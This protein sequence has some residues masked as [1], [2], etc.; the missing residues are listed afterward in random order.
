MDDQVHRLVDRAWA[1]YQ[2]TP[3]NQRLLIGIAGIPGS[4]KTTL[5]RIVSQALNDRASQASPGASHPPPATFLPMD[6]FHL[7]RAALDAMPDPARAHARRGAAFTFDAPKFL[8]LVEA[9]R[10][11]SLPGSAP[12]LAPS[13]DHAIKDPKE[14]DVAVLPTHRIVVLEGNYLAL[15]DR[16]WRDAAALLDELWFVQVD[17]DVARRRLGERHVRAGIAKDLDEG[18]RRARENDL[19]N[20][21]EIVSRR[22]PV[23]EVVQSREDGSWVHE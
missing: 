21:E 19:V 8:R 20:G 1:K 22:L 13:F 14:D 4:G 11:A 18:D 2:A 23:H 16:V 5:S 15:D 6:G 7:T 9:L 12:I 17:F 10:A 3:A